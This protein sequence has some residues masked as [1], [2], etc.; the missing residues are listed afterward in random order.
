[1]PLAAVGDARGAQIAECQPEAVEELLLRV[2]SALGVAIAGEEAGAGGV[3]AVL[4]LPD[5]GAGARRQIAAERVYIA[6]QPGGDQDEH[7]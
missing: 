2:G 3:A 5:D 7:E 6:P 1:V 4:G